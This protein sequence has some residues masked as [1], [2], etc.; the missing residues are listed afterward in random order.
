MTKRE[1]WAPKPWATCWAPKALLAQA[2]KKITQ[3][4]PLTLW[5]SLE[6]YVRYLQNT[7]LKIKYKYIGISTF[8]LDIPSMTEI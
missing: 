1:G 3:R 5:A 2:N 8:L 4:F 7:Q 6:T